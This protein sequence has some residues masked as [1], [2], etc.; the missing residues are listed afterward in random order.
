M[1]KVLRTVTR[2]TLARNSRNMSNYQIKDKSNL[3]ELNK[4]IESKFAEQNKMLKSN[5]AEQNKMLKSNIAELNKMIES[6]LAEQI[7]MMESKFAEQNKIIY[8]SAIVLYGAVGG[9]YGMMY[10]HINEA[11]GEDHQNLEKIS[12]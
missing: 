7:K 11:N 3:A 10:F 4:M 1:F 6:N 2:R 8:R 5:I 12:K 9:L